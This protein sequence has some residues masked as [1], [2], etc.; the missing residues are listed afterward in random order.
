MKVSNKA[1]LYEL[2]ILILQ[3]LFILY[4]WLELLW[5]LEANPYSLVF[6]AGADR[7]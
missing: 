1:F 5:L 7:G 4:S 2:P 3:P 6:L